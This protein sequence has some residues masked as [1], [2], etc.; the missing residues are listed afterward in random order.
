MSTGKKTLSVTLPEHWSKFL[1]RQA[2]TGMDYQVV[3]VTLRDGRVVE[4]GHTQEM[5]FSAIHVQDGGM[6]LKV[7]GTQGAFKRQGTKPNIGNRVAA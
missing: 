4:G 5:G 1:L 7:H 6:K 2:E 3:A